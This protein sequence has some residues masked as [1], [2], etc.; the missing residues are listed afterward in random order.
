MEKRVYFDHDSADGEL[1]EDMR[2]RQDTDCLTSEE[3]GM[4]RAADDEQ[5]RFAADAGRVIIT[6]NRADFA[7]LHAQWMREGKH[8]SGI[9]IAEQSMAVPER[10]RRIRLLLADTGADLADQIVYLN[11]W[12]GVGNGSRER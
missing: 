11:T 1:L 8:H 5:L 4:E 3:A 10:M 9:I 2:L 7:R 6:A 12:F